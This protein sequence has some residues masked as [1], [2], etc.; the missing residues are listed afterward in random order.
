MTGREKIM[1]DKNAC[2][3]D[4]WDYLYIAHPLAPADAIIGFGSY[5][6]SIATRA[7]LLYKAGWA[8][9]ILFTGYLGKGTLGIFQQPEAEIYAQI[10]I[11]EGVPADA[12]LIEPKATNTSENIHFAR[13]LME[14]R[15]LAPR[16]IIAVHKPY[17][18]RRVFAALKMQWPQVEV[19]VAPGN[20]SLADHLAAMTA[21]G[22]EEAEI[23]N[24][25]VGDFLR[26]DAYAK[27]GYQIPQ[28]IPPG[29]LASYEAL[30]KMGYDKYVI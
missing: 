2:L 7:A 11:K 1:M 10:A 6:L 30:V 29:I 28:D 14:D 15:G 12:I 22:V 24:S 17:M 13:R 5:D 21:D 26:M 23:I 3:Q 20:P 25:L 8:P 19:I 16:R 18:T 4:L 27:L 9:V